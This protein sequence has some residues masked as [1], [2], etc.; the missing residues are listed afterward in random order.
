MLS[1][2]RPEIREACGE[3]VGLASV[4]GVIGYVTTQSVC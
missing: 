3:L 2:S 1:S 4:R